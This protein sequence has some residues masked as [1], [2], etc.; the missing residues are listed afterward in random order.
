LT[1]ASVKLYLPPN[2]DFRLIGKYPLLVYVYAGP[3]TQNVNSRFAI[4]WSTYLTTNKQVV[5]ALVDGRGSGYQGDQFMFEVYRRLGTIEV[6]DQLHV[7]RYLTQL[8]PFLD[9][10]RVAM[11]GW[12]YGGYA[13]AM[14][15]AKDDANSLKCAISVAPVTNWRYYGQL[16]CSSLLHS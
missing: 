8:Y 12:S 14:A 4:N 15:L 11:W 6:E 7:I 13:S 16:I 3:G 10:N 9:R 1:D 5:Y 2:I